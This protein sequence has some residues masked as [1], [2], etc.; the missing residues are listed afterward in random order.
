MGRFL[1]NE[2]PRL[3]EFKATSPYFTQAARADGVYKDHPYPFCLPRAC[4]E[5]NLFSEIRDS[6]RSYFKRNE[7][8]WHDGQDGSPSNHLCDSQVCCVNYLF[9]FANKPEALAGLL[10]PVYPQIR[11]MLPIEDGQYVAFE[12]IGQQNY[13]KEKI[14]RNSKRTR[15]ANFTS[16]DA[17]VM[18]RDQSDCV[19]IVLIEWKYTESYFSTPLAVAPSGTDRTRIYAHLYER[20]DCPLI[21]ER[22]PGFESLFYEPF[23]QLMRQQFLAYEMELAHEQGADRVSLLHIAPDH[24]QD[25]KRITSPSLKDLGNSATGLWANLVKKPGAFTS[26]SVEKL[27][28]PFH[29]EDFAELAAWRQYILARYPWVMA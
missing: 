2:K 10:Q 6:A 3:A 12:W 5:E 11:E 18:F 29:S 26:I 19:Q 13:L 9:P 24:N 20:E 7:I 28:G 27:F 4:A 21:K 16:A 25:F 22:I 15:G 8:K 1:E 17:A 14:S 23:Y